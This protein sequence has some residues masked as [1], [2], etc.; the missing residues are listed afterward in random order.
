LKLAQFVFAQLMFRDRQY[1]KMFVELPAS[2]SLVWKLFFDFAA[3]VAA[4]YFGCLAAAAA[5]RDFAAAAL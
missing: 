4:L 5:F 2:I 1:G 3:R